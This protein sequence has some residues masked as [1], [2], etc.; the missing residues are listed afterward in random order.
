MELKSKM[1]KQDR[2]AGLVGHFAGVLFRMFLEYFRV[3]RHPRLLSWFCRHPLIHAILFECCSFLGRIENLC[4]KRL[5]RCPVD[6]GP[7]MRKNPN[8]HFVVCTCSVARIQDTQEICS[9][10]PWATQV[11]LGLF[12]AGWNKGCEFGGRNCDFG[13]CQ[14]VKGT[15][16]SR[17]DLRDR[18]A[19]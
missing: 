18:L 9:S 12:V 1:Q 19:I 11:D 17:E 5:Y 16:A 2:Y 7:V 4:Q 13:S 8:G 6:L 3:E 14:S 10:H 15:S